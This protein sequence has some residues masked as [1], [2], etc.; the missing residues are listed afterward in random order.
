MSVADRACA[1]VVLPREDTIDDTQM[2]RQQMAA[3]GAGGGMP[4]ETQKAF[5]GER[6]ALELVCSL[7][8]TL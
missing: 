3:M 2:M 6:G 8:A 5:D 1:P 7:I 4:M